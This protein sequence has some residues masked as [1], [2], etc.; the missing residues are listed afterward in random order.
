MER[1]KPVAETNQIS[2]TFNPTPSLLTNNEKYYID[3]HV[4]LRLACCLP[5]KL[6]SGMY[7]VV[8]RYTNMFSGTKK[9][10]NSLKYLEPL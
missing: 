1:C 4:G 7:S 3:G 10:A 5:D 8:Q 2:F 6:V 9:H